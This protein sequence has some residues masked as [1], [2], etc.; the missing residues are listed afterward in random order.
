VSLTPAQAEALRDLGEAWPGRPVVIVGATA[1]GFYR[2][3]HWRKTSDVD[4][5]VAAELEEFPLGLERRE[6]WLR[7]R[8]EHEFRAPS[9]AKIDIVPAGPA[10]VG[11]GRLRWPSGREMNLAGFDLAF[12]HAEERAVGELRVKVAPPHVV[13]LLKM[14]AYSDRP[15]DRTRDLADL[16]HLLDEYVD[17]DS[18]RRWA[19]GRGEPDFDL[20]PAYLLGLD[21]AACATEGHRPEVERFLYVVKDPEAVPHALMRREGPKRWA[22]ERDPLE[23]RLAALARGF[24]NRALSSPAHS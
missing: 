16:A 6:G 23:R 3:M 1:L 9:G 17:D 4:L 15:A 11:R 21:L 19:E 12:A 8:H 7:Q 2:D 14:V 5:V 24:G 20:V 22:T 18:E 10:L 13:A